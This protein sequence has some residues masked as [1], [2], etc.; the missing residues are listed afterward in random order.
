VLDASVALAW[1]VDRGAEPYAI[2]VQSKIVKGDRP[3]VPE[4]WQLEIANVLAVVLRKG[5]LTADE[6]EQGLQYY[7]KFLRASAETLR[8]VPAM[9]A[10]FE[11]ARD[12][13]LTSYDALYVELARQ[14]SLPL[15]T[16]DKALRTA[17]VKAGVAVY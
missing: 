10:V 9:R 12:L 7:E 6:I 1:V 15:A 4:F 2:A 16:L 13:K 17:A 8:N 14:E 5:T 3:V 11:A